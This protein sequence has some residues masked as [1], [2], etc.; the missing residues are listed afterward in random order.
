M[1]APERGGLLACLDHA[2]DT[3]QHDRVVALTAALAALLRRDG[4]WA[5]AIT[6]HT[7]AVKAARQLGDRLGQANA[8]NHLGDVRRVTGEYPAATAALDQALAIYRDLQPPGE[9]G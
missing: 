8:L 9:R 3:G 6:R 5:E 2:A 1:G 7:A 4:P